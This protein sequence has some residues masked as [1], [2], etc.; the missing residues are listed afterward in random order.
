M[1]EKGDSLSEDVR[2]RFT[3]HALS[4]ERHLSR[5]QP[6]CGLQPVEVD[7]ARQ[8]GAGEYHLVRAGVLIAVHR[9]RHLAAHQ[10]VH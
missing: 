9:Y 10:I 4:H 7:A 2:I 5:D 8:A 3:R 6:V 1:N